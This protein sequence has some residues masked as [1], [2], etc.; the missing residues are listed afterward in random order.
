MRFGMY[1]LIIALGLAAGGFLWAQ[2]VFVPAPGAGAPPSAAPLPPGGAAVVAPL[3]PATPAPVGPA[4]V[5]L[6]P[7]GAPPTPGLP[8]T[9]GPSP[10]AANTLTLVAPSGFGGGRGDV[11]IQAPAGGM[12]GGPH[13]ELMP[14]QAVRGMHVRLQQAHSEVGMLE[15]HVRE[16]VDQ[17]AKAQDDNQK[18]KLKEEIAKLLD[19]QFEVRQKVREEELAE[20]EK[21]IGQLRLQV[22]KR[23]EKK[24]DIIAH[25]M[26]QLLRE[27]E[28]LGWGDGDPS[29][30]PPR[31][32]AD[33]E[34]LGGPSFV[35]S[36]MA[37]GMPGVGPWREEGSSGSAD[38]VRS[39]EEMRGDDAAPLGGAD[40]F[41]RGQGSSSPSTNSATAE[42]T[43]TTTYGR[44]GG[45]F[46]TEPI[47][48]GSSAS[49]GNRR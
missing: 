48:G 1:S 49:A 2:D 3:P 15:G 45:A 17:I 37:G 43:G 24:G 4:V 14:G 41:S 32:S 13:I 16:A 27:A 47:T 7:T 25:R 26:D 8:G 20:L 39:T 29:L 30:Q 12:P 9:G 42:A 5:A 31:V 11:L 34:V 18:G 44:G 23:R 19:R 36:G 33:F 6:P 46:N 35:W 21:K 38:T 40:N 10:V 28:G 22:N